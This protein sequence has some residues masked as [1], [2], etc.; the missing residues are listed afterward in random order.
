MWEGY[1]PK[2]LST[3]RQK[4]TREEKKYKQNLEKKTNEWFY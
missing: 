1:L 4:K 2:F 3:V